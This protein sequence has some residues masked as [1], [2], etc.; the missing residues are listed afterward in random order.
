M[1]ITKGV[2]GER[3]L[4]NNLQN[5][6]PSD[7]ELHE[8]IIK[9]LSNNKILSFSNDGIEFKGKSGDNFLFI[10]NPVS[11]ELE[12]SRGFV[13]LVALSCRYCQFDLV[14]KY[15]PDHSED[16]LIF[17]IIN[18]ARSLS[19]GVEQFAGCK[20]NLKDVERNLK[21]L[22]EQSLD[23]SYK[24]RLNYLF[25]FFFK[26]FCGKKNLDFQNFKQVF[27]R[28]EKSNVDSLLNNLNNENKFLK[29]LSKLSKLFIEESINKKDENEKKQEEN[30][31][32]NKESKSEKIKKFKKQE[33]LL[34]EIRNQ[35]KKHHSDHEPD[36]LQDR[37]ENSYFK[38][39]KYKAFTKKF[40]L[41]VDA[42][43]IVSNQELSILRNQLDREFKSDE[44]VI[45]KLAKKLEKHLFSIRQN[46]WKFDQD[47][48]YFDNSKFASFIANKSDASIYK[49]IDDNI[50]KN[51]VVTLLLDNSG[52]MRG[53]PIVTAV[54][55]TEIIAKILEK[56]K[57][58]VEI[59]GFT[60]RE[61]KGGQSKKLWEETGKIDKPGRLNDLFHIVYKDSKVSWPVC[62]NNLALVLK[63]GILKE[64]IDGEALIW[65][66]KRLRIKPEKKKILIV[67]SDGAPVD[68]STLSANNSNILDDHLK[69]VV[70]K[71][72]NDNTLQLFAI[73]I[74]H[75]VSKYYKEAFTIDDVNKLGVVLID[76]LVKLFKRSH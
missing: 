26:T 57:V 49:I 5:T 46:F 14:E 69:S 12:I 50:S 48:G 61:W 25:T 8:S 9:S 37:S 11:E 74:G 27:T 54:K 39:Q 58:N 60:T 45:N 23:E 33:L 66:S 41:S 21:L 73:G 68:D 75:D 55:T 51:T 56:C 63:E 28:I 6:T 70:K 19:F 22:L 38:E 13:D 53:K 16:R 10:K 1:N 18:T 17:K 4:K 20:L 71:L 76:N 35:Q 30:L 52:S 32:Q 44:S 2:L 34:E 29:I 3:F 47:E 42:K 67:I 31:S 72:E 59:L 43:K 24:K 64:N 15:I 65:A 36:M 62:K 7:K 40:D